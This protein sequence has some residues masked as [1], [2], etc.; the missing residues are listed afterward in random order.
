MTIFYQLFPAAC[1]I[2]VDLIFNQA[3]SKTLTWEGLL[4][5]HLD[6]K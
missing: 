5:Y 4:S 1:D 3:N 2:I 6:L